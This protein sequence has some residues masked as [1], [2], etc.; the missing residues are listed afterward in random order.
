MTQD[1]KKNSRTENQETMFRP[2]FTEIATFMRAPI[3]SSLDELDIAMIGVPMDLGVTNRAG[4]RHGPREIR[5]A[6]ALMRTIN[7][8]T[9]IEPYDLCNIADAGDV[10][11]D[12]LFSLDEAIR[13]IT[14]YFQQVKTSGAIPLSAG[15]DHSI[16]YPILKGIA[17]EQPVAVIHID[18]HTDTWGEFY[19]SKFHHGAPFRLGVE[20][21]LIDPN[22]MIQIG[23]RGGQNTLEGLEFSKNSGMRVVMMDEF[24]EIG[25][26]EVIKEARRVVG[27]SPTYLTFDVDGIDPVFTPGT[28]TPEIGGITTVEALQLLRGLRGLDFIGGD[29]VEVAPPFDQTGNTALVGATLMFEMLCLIAESVAARRN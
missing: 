9:G 11:I 16:S 24:T 27:D 6:S 2:R 15:G 12:N 3:A 17:S 26:K 14:A 5:N 25:V 8:S 18:A 20:D 1:N 4:A 21:G 28:G 10:P 22:K 23:I 19:G 13:Q 29:V 7:I